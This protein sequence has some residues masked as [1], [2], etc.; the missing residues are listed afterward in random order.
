M[1]SPAPIFLVAGARPNFVKLAPVGRALRARPGLPFKVVHTGQHYAAALS[2][3]F[4][5][6]LEIPPPDFNLGVGSGSHG[7]QTARILERFETLL[8]AERP[9]AVVVFGDVNSTLACSLAAVKLHV[10]VAHVEAGLRSFDRKMPEEINRIVTDTLAGLLLVSEPSGAK[11]LRAEG[12]PDAAIRE[13][14]NVM[15]DSLRAVEPRLAELRPWQVFG[16]APRQYGFVTLHRPANVDD[17]EILRRL[18]DCL[19][20]IAGELPL[21]FAVHPRTRGRL[22]A[23][24]F[25]PPRGLHL[26]EPMNYLDSVAMQRQAALVLTDSGGIQEESSCLDVPC[27]TLRPNT[28][29][30]ITVELGTSTLCGNDP[31]R[32]WAA[33]QDVKAG[34]YRKASAIPLW[35]GRA[36]PRVAS[37]LGEWLGAAA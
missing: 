36:A 37:A 4:F 29:R 24:G 20:K 21:V 31:D 7:A 13:V 22:Q 34:R 14:G 5:E 23:V 15:I 1:T 9:R 16:A 2:D 12:H 6:V 26:A 19:G 17:P 35:D 3:S 32:I 10:P 28:E 18:L 11:N 30:P 8:L 33:Y 27:L 25:A